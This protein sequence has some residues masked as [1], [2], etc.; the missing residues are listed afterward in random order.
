VE[1]VIK[2]AKHRADGRSEVDPK[3]W[4]TS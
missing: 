1:S 4:T 3:N 2:P